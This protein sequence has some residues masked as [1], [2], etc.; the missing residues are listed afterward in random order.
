M[1]EEQYREWRKEN[2]IQESDVID[3]RELNKISET[4]SS[5]VIPASQKRGISKEFLEYEKRINKE[6]KPKSLYE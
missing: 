3:E 5:Q 4:D 6:Y 1:T 2:N